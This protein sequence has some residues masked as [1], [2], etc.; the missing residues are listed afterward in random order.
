MCYIGCITRARSSQPNIGEIEMKKIINGKKY[1]TETAVWICNHSDGY[2]SDFNFIDEDLYRKKTG[3][4]FLA[5]EGG[6]MTEYSHTVSQNCWARGS[7]IFPLT[8]NEARE[9]GE[10]HMNCKEFEEVFGEVAE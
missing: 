8:I 5:G 9:W 2:T 1:D 6:A 7:G 4:F 3:E 10:D